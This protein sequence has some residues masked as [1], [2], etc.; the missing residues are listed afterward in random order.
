MRLKLEMD[1]DPSLTIRFTKIDWFKR[2]RK[3]VLPSIVADRVSIHI[4]VVSKKI[5]NYFK[6]FIDI[7]ETAV[8]KVFH[9]SIFV[10]RKCEVNHK[11]QIS[12]SQDQCCQFMNR[13]WSTFSE[14]MIW[15]WIGWWYSLDCAS[16]IEA[17]ITTANF[18]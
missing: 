12:Q 9:Q 17:Y 16:S 6:A 3:D 15:C 10:S 7:L 8:N 13:S 5:Q 2:F 4:Q 14:C 1:Q 18:L 11:C